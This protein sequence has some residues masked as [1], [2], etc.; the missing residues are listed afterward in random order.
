[1]RQ[2]KIYYQELGGHYHCRVFIGIYG[3]TFAKVGDLVF[4]ES[5]WTGLPN[6]FA[7]GTIFIEQTT[8]NKDG[9]L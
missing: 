9:L 6:T 7:H 8:E 3:Q 4:S 1:M 5:D 2:L